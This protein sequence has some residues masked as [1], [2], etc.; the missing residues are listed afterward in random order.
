MVAAGD[1]LHGPPCRRWNHLAPA[2]ARLTGMEG[3]RLVALLLLAVAAQARGAP[4]DLLVEG[5]VVDDATGAPIASAT[6]S[7]QERR[8]AEPPATTD[9]E[10]RFRLVRETIEP[11]SSG[12]GTGAQLVASA[13]GWAP[14]SIRPYPHLRRGQHTG[15]VVRLS[16]PIPLSG[17]VVDPSGAP[18]EGAEVQ[19]IGTLRCEGG[20]C[21]GTAR[22]HACGPVDWAWRA[23]TNAAGW[24]AIDDLAPDAP[25]VAQV[26]VVVTAA[27]RRQLGRKGREVRPGDPPLEVVL[28]PE[29]AIEGTVVDATGAPIEGAYVTRFGVEVPRSTTRIPRPPEDDEVARADRFSVRYEGSE[30]ASIFDRGPGRFAGSTA[31]PAYERRIGRLR[32]H[33]TL[34]GADGRFA[35]GPLTPVRQLLAVGAPGRGE[36]L[37]EVDAPASSLRVVLAP[38][39]SLRGQVVRAGVPVARAI[40]RVLEA[41]RADV[42]TRTYLQTPPDPLAWESRFERGAAITDAEGRFEVGGLSDRTVT[43]VAM[44]LEDHGTDLFAQRDDVPTD[45]EPITLEVAPWEAR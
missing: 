39:R 28:A 35:L 37:V 18:L 43:V 32:G 1:G 31:E 2:R 24:F 40:V 34:S 15:L 3:R 12:R 14:A 45:G 13:P 17:R 11:V 20:G 4:P 7:V 36:V 8:Y 30:P 19:V 38:A 25:G 33:V 44:K 29:A 21:D 10:G 26:Y 22:D 27:K 6:V 41:G 9:G 5:R 23:T 16:R 42:V